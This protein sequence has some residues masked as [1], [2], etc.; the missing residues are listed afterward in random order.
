LLVHGASAGSRTFMVPHGG[1]IRYLVEQGFDVWTLDWRSSNLF[2]S[3][4]RPEHRHLARHERKRV[5]YWS[6][7]NLDNAARFD[8]LGAL[9]AIGKWLAR[10]APLS[11]TLPRSL[12]EISLVA[13]CVGG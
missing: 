8:L 12:P 13:H 10:E 11:A 5:P 2:S 9:D 3:F 1:L 6:V 7:F 4:N